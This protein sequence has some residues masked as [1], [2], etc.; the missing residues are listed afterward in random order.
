MILKYLPIDQ[1][2]KD[3]TPILARG[4]AYEKLCGVNNQTTH[5]V[6]EYGGPSPREGFDWVVLNTN[7]HRVYFLP[8]DFIHLPE[9]A[10]PQTSS[11][12]LEEA[13]AQVIIREPTDW[14]P[15][16]RVKHQIN[17]KEQTFN[18]PEETELLRTL[19][20]LIVENRQI[21]QRRR[22]RKQD[23]QTYKRLQQKYGW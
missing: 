13:D 3:G 14:G 21:E 11:I 12:V 18:T 22:Q 19:A 15:P 10:P 2:P 8:F 16:Q 7:Y 6:V 23:L 20:T 1:A 17:L 4:L 9:Y 5:A